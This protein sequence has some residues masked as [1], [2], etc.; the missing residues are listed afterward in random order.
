MHRMLQNNTSNRQVFMFI[1]LVYIYYTNRL[2]CKGQ[3]CENR[4][5]NLPFYHRTH[6]L[7]LPKD[8]VLVLCTHMKYQK[9]I[10]AVNKVVYLCHIFSGSP[11]IDI[12][13][14]FLT[15][16]TW[17]TKKHISLETLHRIHN[18][19]ISHVTQ[20]CKN[21][22]LASVDKTWFTLKHQNKPSVDALQNSKRRSIVI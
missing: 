15:C 7:S 20:E 6:C 19:M 9:Q 22:T 11:C 16:M 21:F 14:W 13:E 1:V 10:K 18:C 4:K 8:I 2:S 3:T 12:K 5:R 17:Y